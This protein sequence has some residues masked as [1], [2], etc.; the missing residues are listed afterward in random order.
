MHV[1]DGVEHPKAVPAGALGLVHGDVRLLQQLAGLGQRVAG[2]H[3]ADAPGDGE[4]VAVL[5][6]PLAR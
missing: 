2:H 4:V 5:D 3:H 6:E 1:R